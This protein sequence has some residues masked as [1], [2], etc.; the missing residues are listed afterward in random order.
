MTGLHDRI[1][2]LARQ[3]DADPMRIGVLSTG[4]ACAVALLLGRLD[5]LG[6]D[7][8]HP[9]DALERLGPDWEKAVRDLH[10]HGWKHT[11]RD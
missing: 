11:P 2:N 6:A 9:L 10:R 1:A 7:Y 5:L 3:V 8:K 4:E